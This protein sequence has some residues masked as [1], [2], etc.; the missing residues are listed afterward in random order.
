MGSQLAPERKVATKHR[1]CCFLDLSCC[2]HSICPSHKGLMEEYSPGA[3]LYRAQSW[4][5][6]ELNK[7][8]LF[9]K[10]PVWLLV[11]PAERGLVLSCVEVQDCSSSFPLEPA[12][13]AHA[14]RLSWHLS[15][16]LCLCNNCCSTPCKIVFVVRSQAL[17]GSNQ[18]QQG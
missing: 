17:W 9:T 18:T 15:L 16:L 8:P 11:R 6:H 5:F 4:T 3:S 10:Y 1:A 14:D 7:P 12:F 13:F 2:L